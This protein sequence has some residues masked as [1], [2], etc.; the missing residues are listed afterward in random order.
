MSLGAALIQRDEL[1]EGHFHSVWTVGLI[2][3]I[4]TV[5]FLSAAAFPIGRF[6]NE[7]RLGFV[8]IV[9]AV[10]AS[11]SNLVSP[12]T[13]ILNRKLVFWH[14]FLIQSSQKLF[15]FLG[16]VISA[17]IWKTYWAIVIGHVTGVLTSLILTYVISPYRPKIIFSH[18]KE[19]FS[20]SVWLAL[21][22]FVV[23]IN[24]RIEQLI[25]GYLVG[26][27]TLGLYSMA[28]SLSGMPVREGTAPLTGTLFPAFSRM[29]SDHERLERAF[30][31]AHSAVA[32]AAM[33]L[34]VGFALVAD[35]VTRLFLGQKWQAAIPIMQILSISFAISGLTNVMHPLIMA[36]N[37]TKTLFAR[38]LTGLVIRMPTIF[39]G[40][41]VDGLM[42]VV[43]ARILTSL[44]SVIQSMVIV[45]NIGAIS[46]RRQAVPL[47]R[48]CVAALAMAAAIWLLNY[49]VQFGSGQL[50]LMAALIVQ[51]SVG[52]F[53]YVA[54]LFGL[55]AAMGNGNDPEAAIVGYLA[56]IRAN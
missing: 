34:G 27:S 30:L 9:V 25:L 39:I 53:V 22:S 11:L 47:V 7:P 28:D 10:A 51:A 19:L 15:S 14:E 20:F 17:I 5:T 49:S 2:R 38:D 18:F 29:A 24:S 52:G 8:L 26:S 55:W 12:K 35:P 3:A 43:I 42:G 40:Y 16:T 48:P 1:E 32:S 56:K 44:V 4:F 21:C 54:A 6:Y 46:L 31:R 41:W 50:A 37:R 13:I 23:N 33:P 45:R 36:L